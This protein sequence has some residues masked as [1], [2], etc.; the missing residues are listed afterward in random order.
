MNKRLLLSPCYADNEYNL[1]LKALESNG[2]LFLSAVG[3]SLAPV[4]SS[5]RLPPASICV[6][7]GNVY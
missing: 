6:C 7:I 1:L 3:I 5:A 4:R 2:Q